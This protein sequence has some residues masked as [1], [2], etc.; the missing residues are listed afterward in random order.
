MHDVAPHGNLERVLFRQEATTLWVLHKQCGDS[1]LIRLL[2]STRQRRGA[3]ESPHNSEEEPRSDSKKQK[4]QKPNHTY[5]FP[6]FC[7]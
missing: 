5:S 3:E 2:L 7:K 6:G 1:P 4:T